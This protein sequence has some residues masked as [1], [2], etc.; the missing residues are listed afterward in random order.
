MI[1]SRGRKHNERSAPSPAGELQQLR[2][3]VAE[4]EQQAAAGR[5]AQEA[6]RRDREQLRV[7][8]DHVAAMV[9]VADTDGHWLHV[10]QHMIDALG[11]PA[12]ELLQMRMDDVV[13][14][15][16][17]VETAGLL[18]RLLQHE[19]RQYRT[20]CRYLR[21]DGSI[22]WVDLSIS[23]RH[24]EQG[25]VESFVEV[26]F[27]ITERK[28]AIDALQESERKFRAIADYT[29]D[30][31]I[32]VGA[33]GRPI[34]L[35]PVVERFTG[36]TVEECL[37]MP[38]FPAPLLP[39]DDRARMLALYRQ[40]CEGS[41]GNDVQYRLRHR[42]GSTTWMSASW[43]PIYSIDGTC[44]GW[45]ASHRDI[46]KRKRAETELQRTADLLR[47]I[48][49]AQELYITGAES[50]QV[51]RTLLQTLVTMTNS[52]YG[53]LDEILRDENDR[54]Y[55]R[56]LAISDIS[57]DEESR[58]LYEGLTEG[59]V[60]FHNLDN[61]AG[62]P[63]L[64]GKPIIANTPPHD[65]RSRGT[66]QGHP[67]IR[68]FMGLPLC[69]GGQVIGV[70]GVANRPGGYSP[71]IAEFLEPFVAT[72]AGI[73]HAVREARKQEQYKEALR[74]SEETAR[75]LLNAPGT[76][77]VLLDRDGIVLGLNRTLA[78]FLG[79]P[80]Q[81]VVGQSI[82]DFFPPYVGAARKAILEKVLQ[83]KQVLHHEE[84]NRGRW[85][86][87]V[88]YPILSPAGDVHRVAVLA[89]DITAYK[90]MQQQIEQRQAEFLH[91]SRLNTLGEMASGLAHELNQPLAAIMSFA[92]ASLRS[93]QSSEMD[94][95]RLTRNIEQIVAQSTRAGEIIRRVRAFAQRRPSRMS[96]LHI[97][98][99][100]HDALGLLGPDLRH[101]EIEVAL[102]LSEDLPPVLADIIQLEQVLLNLMRNAI[103][104]M[105]TVAAPRRLTLCT[106][107]E[108]KAAVKVMVS[109]TG[110]GIH[111]E[112]MAKVF[113]PFFTT[114]E[115]GLGVGLSI[116][117]SIIEL[118]RGQFR[119]DP[120]P[121][122]GCTFTFTLPTAPPDLPSDPPKAGTGH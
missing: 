20:E 108:P 51:Y 26:G 77:A 10:N 15:Q 86:D 111:P 88:V 23:P 11:Y 82:W 72:C 100:I 24:N 46:A 25:D 4:L 91:V 102:E 12:D 75:A 94:K 115:D 59:S 35:N 116:S 121:G 3:R 21:K 32:W 96:C 106:G 48:K 95:H 110:P 107:I 105:E 92:G 8:F 7:V 87:T 90:R 47:A 39:E 97:N 71:Q 58:R 80:E 22:L 118:H 13:H 30:L 57:W 44:L 64:T 101:K 120:G 52:E 113:D 78:D 65:P 54:P 79:R 55:K 18:G 27:N 50:R 36:Y 2:R 76:S 5:R 37:A 45:R 34:W 19:T 41:S 9:A 83:S 40:A 66:P 67:P 31:E 56:S 98:E 49:D 103:E 104:A 109:D 112:I 73:I 117:R 122:R 89:R 84:E 81:E 38:D 1:R 70:A 17:R 114:K 62:A 14:P 68:A 33:H 43:Q 119:V 16:D 42:N 60:E 85:S 74:E 69:F 6:L 93:I 29:C 61:L 63:V 53:F 99:V 28:K